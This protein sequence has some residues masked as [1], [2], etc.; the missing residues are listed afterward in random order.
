MGRSAVDKL[1]VSKEPHGRQS[2]WDVM[3]EFPDW[4]TVGDVFAP[5][6]VNRRT[7]A[8]F[9]QCLVAGGFAEKEVLGVNL[10]RYRLIGHLPASAPR[11]RP[12][13]TK[14]EDGSGT[15]NMWRSMRMLPRFNHREIAAL[16]TTSKI[17]VSERTARDYCH[18]L[19]ATGYLRVVKPAVPNKSLSVFRLIRNN[20][21]KPPM[22][23]R[24]K[25]VF[26][27]NTDEVFTP[28]RQS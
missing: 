9:L 8:S 1:A 5:T 4:F 18:S 21:P 22:I 23:Q 7:I 17:K 28:E 19:K 6:F 25:Q 20:G 12:D 2:L 27:P 16:A 10:V 13:G 24:V 3:V 15:E 11:L 14:I 26:D